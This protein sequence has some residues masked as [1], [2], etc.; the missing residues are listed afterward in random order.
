MNEKENSRAQAREPTSGQASQDAQKSA[1]T[2]PAAPQM[3]GTESTVSAGAPQSRPSTSRPV[4]GAVLARVPPPNAQG[5]H[6]AGW[7]RQPARRP[8]VAVAPNVDNGSQS[9]APS[10]VDNGSQ[11]A[12]AP[13]GDARVRPA[14]P[15][16]NVDNGSQVRPFAVDPD[17]DEFEDELTRSGFEVVAPRDPQRMRALSN[18]DS[19][20]H[21]SVVRRPL[22]GRASPHPSLSAIDEDALDA[23]DDDFAAP[24]SSRTPEKTPGG[25]SGSAPARAQDPGFQVPSFPMRPQRPVVTQRPARV[26]ARVVV[27]PSPLRPS[28]DLVAEFRRVGRERLA[29]HRKPESELGTDNRTAETIH[30]Y[31]KRGDML[32]KRYRREMNFPPQEGLDPMDFAHW[33]LS[34]R[35]SIK[36]NTWRYYRQAGMMLLSSFSSDGAVE[37]VMLLQS[38]AA[39][40]IEMGTSER[41]PKPGAQRMSSGL[42]E[43]QFPLEDFER[44]NAWLRVRAKSAYIERLRDWI[45]AG[46]ATGLRPDEWKAT[47]VKSTPDPSQENGRRIYLF[48]LNA[49]STNG[50][51]H[52]P[53]RTIDITS[54]TIQ[55]L[56]AVSR[57]SQNGAS[58]Y[59]DGRFEHVQDACAQLLYRACGSLWPRRRRHYAL[60]SC[61]HQ[62]ISNMRSVGTKRDELSAI[63]GHLVTETQAENYGKRRSGWSVDKIVDVPK[64]VPE[65]VSNVRRSLTQA[66]ERLRLIALTKGGKVDPGEGEAFDGG[67]ETSAELAIQGGDA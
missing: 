11:G 35:L 61:R 16:F 63:L 53:V 33:L 36:A 15:S 21:G 52:G 62:F 38:A 13:G 46:I 64:A 43:K 49:K 47:E 22:P 25:A 9:R 45:R 27:Q 42:K 7:V 30:S 20:S 26:P 50:R 44:V 37:A 56:E 58:W 2:R 17:P 6:T 65:D 14:A 34:L 41:K 67:Y 39:A 31:R 10:N 40:D 4:A 59:L 3:K 18:V 54:F 29:S 48:V 23:L 28:E 32:Q 66:D 55:T 12:G 51:S 57:M 5:A 1:Q 8:A 19:G 60:Y 24:A